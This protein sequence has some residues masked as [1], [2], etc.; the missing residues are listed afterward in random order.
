MSAGELGT[1]DQVL[2]QMGF[3]SEH[4]LCSLSLSTTCN[5]ALSSLGSKA[6]GLQ[7][8]DSIFLH[9]IGSHLGVMKEEIEA[10]SWVELGPW[11]LPGL[12]C[13]SED[14]NMFE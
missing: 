7:V 2:L 6:P 9:T 12:N 5:L 13:G 4:P 10:I 3:G 8:I 11:G 14:V 1:F